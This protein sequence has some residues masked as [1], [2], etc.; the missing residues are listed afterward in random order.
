[1]DI[2]APASSRLQREN[3]RGR[4][5]RRS[6][7]RGGKDDSDRSR[8]C[9]RRRR[10]RDPSRGRLRS[11]SRSR[12]RRDKHTPRGRSRNKRSR[13]RS[14]RQRGRRTGI[15]PRNGRGDPRGG[16]RDSRNPYRDEKSPSREK[17]GRAHIP[18]R[19]DDAAKTTQRDRCTP[20]PTMA[21]GRKKSVPGPSEGPITASVKPLC[22]PRRPPG[23]R[24]R[25][26]ANTP[27]SIPG[28]G[29]GTNLHYSSHPTK[30]VDMGAYDWRHQKLSTNCAR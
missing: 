18:P 11:C 7:S 10:T 30:R 19:R 28:G 27:P 6:R 26:V 15:T 24:A 2:R 29:H 16:F 13:S 1:M 3:R 22:H 21:I 8:S 17:R 4:H 9:S 14:N 23:E 20:T 5:I 25:F 12:G